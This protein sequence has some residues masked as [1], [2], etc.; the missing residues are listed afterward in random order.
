VYALN[1]RHAVV[2]FKVHVME[3]GTGYIHV[4]SA[5][6]DVCLVS[7]QTTL[8]TSLSGEFRHGAS[9]GQQESGDTWHFNCDYS[10]GPEKSTDVKSR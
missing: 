8:G 3:D 9:G 6:D 1:A 4:L 2:F 10:I 5:S 7:L